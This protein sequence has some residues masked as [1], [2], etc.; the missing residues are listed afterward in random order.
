M[1]YDIVIESHQK[2]IDDILNN[3]YGESKHFFEWVDSR[4]LSSKRFKKR[5][6]VVSEYRIFSIKIGKMS[7]SLNKNIKYLDI[8]DII[9]VEDTIEIRQKATSVAKNGDQTGILIRSQHMD[10][11]QKILKLLREKIRNI[12]HNYPPS[13]QLKINSP[14]SYLLPLEPLKVGICDHFIETYKAQSNYRNAAPSSEVIR[15]VEKYNNDNV[16]DFDLSKCPGLEN[17]N[18]LSFSIEIVLLS[19]SYNCY[20]NSI[21]INGSSQKNIIQTAGEVLK[22]N[23]FIKK[24]SI[25]GLKEDEQSL[26]GLGHSLGVNGFNTLQVLDLHSNNINQQSFSV[27]AEGLEFLQHPLKYLNLSDCNLNSR[28]IELLFQSLYRNPKMSQHIEYINVSNSKFDEPGSNSLVNWLQKVKD[29]NSI[30]YL[31]LSNCNI[32]LITIG[33]QLRFFSN[34]KVLDISNNRLERT[35]IEEL[36][37]FIKSSKGLESLD[38]SNCSLNHDYFLYICNTFNKNENIK[39]FCLNVSNN[40]IIKNPSTFVSAVEFLNSVHTLNISNIPIGYKTLIRVIDSIRIYCKE[41]NTLILDSTFAGTHTDKEGFD[42]INE[43]KQLLDETKG[44]KGLSMAGGDSFIQLKYLV[45]LMGYLANSNSTLEQLNISNNHLGDL[46]APY[47]ANLFEKNST[48]K[49]IQIDRNNFTIN[50]YQ[51]ILLGIQNNHTLVNIPFP[52]IDFEKI[53]LS[54][55]TP[56]KKTQLFNILS[57]I[58]RILEENGQWGVKDP[59]YCPTPTGSGSTFTIAGGSNNNN[60]YSSSSRSLEYNKIRSSTG[61]HSSN[62]NYQYNQQDQYDY[63]QQ[64]EGHY[65][66]DGQYIPPPP[67]T[68][69]TSYEDYDY[70]NNNYNQ[71]LSVKQNA[72]RATIS[73]TYRAGGSNGLVNAISEINFE[74]Q[75]KSSIKKI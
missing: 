29:N 21:I 41:L 72:N 26:A 20:F 61:S 58:E 48:L 4:S 63:S 28:S 49:S 74:D 65:D 2:F 40:Q 60:P 18:D 67:A 69:T 68:A 57:K 30:K 16:I 37:S 31:Y 34:I 73:P 36:I 6:L 9:V 43:V 66:A 10:S 22:T 14:D 35:E 54:L 13:Q 64:S 27:F 51:T 70:Y 50:T 46:L 12:T 23:C 45:P 15:L 44:L 7:T 52:T 59:H 32:N 8:S 19:L 47:L 11:L 38:I 56:A 1:N 42:F 24:I 71:S 17:K 62:T 53:L 5:I 25:S 3:H 75:R 33:A 39:K 55:S